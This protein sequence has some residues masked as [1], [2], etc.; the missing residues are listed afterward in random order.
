MKYLYCR[1]CDYCYPE[2][3]FPNCAIC[4]QFSKPTDDHGNY[5]Y[6]CDEHI[7]EITYK[8]FDIIL[9]HVCKQKFKNEDPKILKELDKMILA[10]DSDESY[11]DIKKVVTN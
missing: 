1:E 3:D 9:C 10:Y 5:G 6:V 4:N 2:E 7:E 8:D 11:D